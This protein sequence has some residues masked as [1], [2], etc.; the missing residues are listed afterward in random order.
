MKSIVMEIVNRLAD[1]AASLDAMEAALIE[2]GVLRTGDIGNRFHNHKK[3]V[4]SHLVSLRAS[5]T[6]LPE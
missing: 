1:T 4:E 3:I 5:I 6:L 2:N